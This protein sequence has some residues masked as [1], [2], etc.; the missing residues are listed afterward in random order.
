[1]TLTVAIEIAV[2]L[3]TAASIFIGLVVYLNNKQD[4]KFCDSHSE[5]INMLHLQVTE[6]TT[7][8]NGQIENLQIQINAVQREL[9]NLNNNINIMGRLAK[10]EELIHEK[11]KNPTS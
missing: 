7:K 5:I 11:V 4:K 10:M 6:S 3:F 1:M 2:G 8:L 9:S